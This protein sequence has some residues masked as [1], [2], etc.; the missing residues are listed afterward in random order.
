M[1]DFI[2]FEKPTALRCHFCGNQTEIDF[3]DASSKSDRQI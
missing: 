2:G 3:S 1:W